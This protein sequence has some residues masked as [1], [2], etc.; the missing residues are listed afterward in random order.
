MARKMPLNTATTI[1]YRVAF[2]SIRFTKA[3]ITFLNEVNTNLTQVRITS[4][5]NSKTLAT[6]SAKPPKVLI[7]EANIF[8]T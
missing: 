7:A 1:L 6:T 4:I 2:V 8:N 3:S 5:M